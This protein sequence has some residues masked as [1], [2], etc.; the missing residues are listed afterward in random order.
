MQIVLL[1]KNSRS[2]FPYKLR[3]NCIA[4]QSAFIALYIWNNQCSLLVLFYV[5]RYAEL[6]PTIKTII[7]RN[8]LKNVDDFLASS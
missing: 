5:V 8:V 7:K 6:S 3:V 4:F 1:E 2:T